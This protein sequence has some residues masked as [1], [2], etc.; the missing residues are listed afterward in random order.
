[1]GVVKAL[2][3]LH[4]LTLFL[5]LAS[6]RETKNE[7]GLKGYKFSYVH[8]G[9][10]ILF[11]FLPTS[12]SLDF[13][14]KQ[15]ELLDDPLR[16]LILAF[17]IQT[18]CYNVICFSNNILHGYYLNFI[19]RLNL[20]DDKLKTVHINANDVRSRLILL[21]MTSFEYWVI[22][23]NFI[24]VRYFT[25]DF[26][27][28]IPIF[29]GQ[30]KDVVFV[31]FF[32]SVY[33]L[34]YR[35]KLVND[36]LSIIKTLYPE[37]SRDIKLIMAREIS[38]LCNIH[39]ELC[40]LR[41]VICKAFQVQVVGSILTLMVFNLVVFNETSKNYNTFD[42]HTYIML[43]VDAICCSFALFVLA[44]VCTKCLNQVKTIY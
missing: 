32:S 16:F 11:S 37:S 34:Y 44:L 20:T 7:N 17:T 38:V 8:S 42:Y 4:V 41:V 22:I 1:M 5:G 10:T 18:V 14:K 19:N 30:T 21:A 35:F 23:G 40:V 43:C 6:Y 39:G 29:I 27:S 2:R 24:T 3:P 13:L 33:L 28:L 36:R 15:F 26:F 31:Q 9:L 12:W 25:G